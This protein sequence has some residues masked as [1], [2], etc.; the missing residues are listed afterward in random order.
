M[1]S[2]QRSCFRF[3]LLLMILLPQI[4]VRCDSKPQQFFRHIHENHLV[5]SFF[6]CFSLGQLLCSWICSPLKKYLSVRSHEVLPRKRWKLVFL[7]SEWVGAFSK[8]YPELLP[9]SP[10]AQLRETIALFHPTGSNTI[11]IFWMWPGIV[12]VFDPVE[13]KKQ[14]SALVRSH[15]CGSNTIQYNSWSDR[16]L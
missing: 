13:S 7:A 5:H 4:R 10:G 16:G 9:A 15:C 8:I 2:K 1:K 12:I 3:G 6:S 14:S 11:T